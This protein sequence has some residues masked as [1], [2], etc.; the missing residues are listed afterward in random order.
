MMIDV[1]N[2]KRVNDAC[3]HQAGDIVLKQVADI[4]ARE[5]RQ[6]DIAARYGGDEFVVL[7]PQ[8]DATQAFH[9]ARRIRDGVRLA[10]AELSRTVTGVAL[11]VGIAD[12]HT[13]GARTGDM[14]VRAADK[15]LYRVKS[16]GKDAISARPEPVQAA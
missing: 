10:L 12:L 1:D 5:V 11:S 7:L 2:F 14:L 15:A 13:S 3:G 8:C 16:M 4:V 6:S 9:L